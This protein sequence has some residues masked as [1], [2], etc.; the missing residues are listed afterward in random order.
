MTVGYVDGSGLCAILSPGEPGQRGAAIWK[1]LD[2]VCAYNVVE[3]EVPSRIGRE[4]N[5]VAWIWT[6]QSLT[7]VDW[8]ADMQRQ[9]VDLAWLGAPTL[10]AA[11]V[12][13]AEQLGADHFLSAN[14][15]AQSWADI[16]GLNVVAL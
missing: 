5:R 6:M 3:F 8:T 7:L 9:A 12:A 14:R 11:H 16:R 2:A 1:S 4:L 10:V 13:C 15:Q